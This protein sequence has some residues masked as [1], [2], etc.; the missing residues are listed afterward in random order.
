MTD[1]PAGRHHQITPIFGPIRAMNPETH[2]AHLAVCRTTQLLDTVVAEDVAAGWQ[3]MDGDIVEQAARATFG[4]G[5]LAVIPGMGAD[6]VEA[7]LDLLEQGVSVAVGVVDHV[8]A[9]RLYDQARRLVPTSWYDETEPPPT[10]GL[11]LTQLLLL[12][13]L[14]AGESVGSAA[15]NEHLSERTASRRLTA[16]RIVLGVR[17]NAEAARVV[18]NHLD[19]L[20][21][22]CD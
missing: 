21:S 17:S 7:T 2:T 10:A 5:T 18:A 20:R 16:A 8:V 14:A 13:R 22:R 15:A 11:D 1:P 19:R 12:S 3:V 6:D 9:V 4:P